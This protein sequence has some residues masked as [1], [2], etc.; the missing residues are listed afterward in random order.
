MGQHAQERRSGAI[1]F[2]RWMRWYHRRSPPSLRSC[3]SRDGR[4]QERDRRA[5]LDDAGRPAES[6]PAPPPLVVESVSDLLSNASGN[7]VKWPSRNTPLPQSFQS[8]LRSNST[9]GVSARKRRG[10]SIGPLAVSIRAK[11]VTSPL[12]SC[13]IRVSHHSRSVMLVLA[14]RFENAVAGVPVGS[15]RD[16]VEEAMRQ[17]AE[18]RRASGRRI[19]GWRWPARAGGPGVAVTQGVSIRIYR[20]VA[21]LPRGIGVRDVRC[22]VHSASAA[23]AG[24]NKRPSAFRSDGCGNH[25]P[26]DS[27]ALSNRACCFPAC[28]RKC[29]GR[30]R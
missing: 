13:V 24:R 19:A 26:T 27:K 17:A 30:R 5:V 16:V 11:A 3:R 14:R 8:K 15:Q 12:T 7:R 20:S 22:C 18:R 2:D 23:A 29:A 9:R 6:S 25:W 28:L 10:F 1:H 21:A 4:D